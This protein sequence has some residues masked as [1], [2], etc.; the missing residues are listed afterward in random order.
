[1]PVGLLEQSDGFTT[2][3]IL[4]HGTNEEFDAFDRMK[5][6]TARH[7][8]TTPDIETAKQYGRHVYVV[9]GRQSPQANLTAE[10]CDYELLKKLYEEGE[11]ESGWDLSFDDFHE[12]ITSGELYGAT[13]GFQNEVIETCLGM[14]YKTVRITDGIP[15]SYGGFGDSVIFDDPNDLKIIK[16]LS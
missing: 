16:K 4:Y 12:R 8:Y 1:M 13:G 3:E 14:G 2:S 15:G 6:K 10:N 7:I 5:A 11:F 9:Y